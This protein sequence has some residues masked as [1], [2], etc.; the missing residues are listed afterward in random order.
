MTLKF[1]ATAANGDDMATVLADFGRL[2]WPRSDSAWSI[3]LRLGARHLWRVQVGTSE[4]GQGHARDR[5]AGEDRTTEP[6]KAAGT[7]QASAAQGAVA[8]ALPGGRATRDRDQCLEGPQ[9]LFRQRM[10][11]AQDAGEVRYVT[12]EDIAALAHDVAHGNW[13]RRATA[14]ELTGEWIVYAQH[15][16]SNYYLCLGRHVCL[17]RHNNSSDEYLRSQIDAI[18]CQEFP[19]LT[20]LLSAS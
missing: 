14:A 11:E 2:Y 13:Q 17:G 19:F 9:P 16:G 12:Q 4:P 5:G 8:Q 6:A 10:H 20:T 1:I 7:V 15:E 18:C 3:Q